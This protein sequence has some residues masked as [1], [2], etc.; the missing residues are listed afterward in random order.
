MIREE[1]KNLSLI[2]E[3]D[4]P[5]F[6][7]YVIDENND[8]YVEPIFYSQLNGFKERYKDK[9]QLIVDAIIERVK[10]NHKV[11]FVGDYEENDFE[12][13]GYII[14]EIQDITNPLQIFVEDKSRGSDYGD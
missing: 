7:H 3:P 5:L 14:L 13:P 9:Y 4:Y 12:I 8:F 2:K 6:D 1:F 10:K 11:I